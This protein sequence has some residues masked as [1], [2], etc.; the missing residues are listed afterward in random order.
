MVATWLLLLLSGIGAL[1][2]YNELGFRIYLAKIM[3]NM[4]NTIL[5]V[6]TCILLI[7]RFLIKK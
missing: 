5:I 1:F 6:F 2:W 7:V 4:V 3:V